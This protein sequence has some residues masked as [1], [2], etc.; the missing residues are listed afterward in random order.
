MFKVEP[1]RGKTNNL[2][3]RPSPTQT[4]L[5]SHM[6]ARG[7]KLWKKRRGCT[8]PVAKTKALISFAVTQTVTAKLICGLVSP[9]QIVDFLMTWLSF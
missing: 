5:Y 2:G 8:I 3:F 4:S 7:L 1:P 9:M 6:Q